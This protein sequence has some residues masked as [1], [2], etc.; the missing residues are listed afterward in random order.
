MASLD[1]SMSHNVCYGVP[2]IDC[3]YLISVDRGDFPVTDIIGEY[4]IIDP[5]FLVVTYGTY[6]LSDVATLRNYALRRVFSELE[7]YF[8]DRLEGKRHSFAVLHASF[9]CFLNSENI[10]ECRCYFDEEELRPVDFT[11]SMSLSV[12]K[13][14]INKG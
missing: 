1:G 4:S 11:V 9:A 7:N 14:K 12:V 8:P 13:P 3:S 6:L 2:H 5:A 10:Y